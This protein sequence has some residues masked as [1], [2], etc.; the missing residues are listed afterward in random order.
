MSLSVI[1]VANL[2]AGQH[3]A[4]IVDNATTSKLWSVT[5]YSSAAPGDA[6]APT[7]PTDIPAFP[8]VDAVELD[9]AP[10]GTSNVGLIAVSITPSQEDTTQP[11][12]YSFEVGPNALAI[13][14]STS[15][16]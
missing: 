12:P 14:A 13:V 11:G 16:G 1:P 5:P 4:A 7:V 8:T 9:E 10:D 6:E 2:T 3:L 15:T